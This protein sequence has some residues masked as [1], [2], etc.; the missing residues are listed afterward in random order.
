MKGFSL[1]LA[2]ILIATPATVSAAPARPAP[3][4]T[5]VTVVM[6]DRGFHPQVIRLRSGVPYRLRF[7]NRDDTTHDFF[8]PGLLNRAVITREEGYKLRDGRLNVPPHGEASLALTPTF[9]AA[10]TAKS[11]KALDVVSNMKAQILVY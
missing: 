3:R 11:T 2:T 9:A 7:I 4:V 10:Y 5:V 6:A 8:A 1:A